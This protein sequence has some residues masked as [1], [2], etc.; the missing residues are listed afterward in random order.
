M[1]GTIE[2]AFIGT[3]TKPTTLQWS[4]NGNKWTRL[5]VAVGSGEDVQWL[6]VATFG[7]D[8]ERIAGM[9]KGT[10]IYVEGKLKMDSWDYEGRQYH[11]LNVA[12]WKCE[13]VM[14]SAIGRNRER[15]RH[16]E[17]PRQDPQAPLETRP[18]LSDEIPF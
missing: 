5:N 8:A 12:A 9:P 17:R 4:Q 1:H 15:K 11:G 13:P 6:V 10:R 7:D 3:L 14:S 16:D 2:A 18:N